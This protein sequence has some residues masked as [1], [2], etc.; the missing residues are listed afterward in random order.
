MNGYFDNASTSFPKPP[1]VGQWID[2]YLKGGGTYGRS[3]HRKSFEVARVVEDTRDRMAALL[4]ISNAENLVFCSSATEGA[5]TLL[6]G[7]TL[8]H[9]RVLVDAMSHNA[10]MRP[11]F[12]L[13]ESAGVEYST[14]PFHVDGTV[15]VEGLSKMM[16]S[17][18][19]LVIIN[20]ASNVNGIVQDIP[21]I[22]KVIGDV[23][24]LLDTSQSAGKVDICADNWGV[25]YLFFT[26][27]KG[28]LGPTGVGGFYASNPDLISPFKYGGTGSNS[29]SEQ[30]PS[31]N[32]DR[33]E[34]G[35]PNSLGIYGLY[36]ALNASIKAL[37]KPDDFV[38]FLS[39]VKALK[40]YEVYCAGCSAKQT[41][42]FS[43]VHRTKSNDELAFM[44]DQDFDIQVRSGLHCAPSAHKALGTF[45]QG[46]VRF[47]ASPFHSKDDFEYL[48]RTLE[49]IK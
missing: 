6:Q 11:L 14:I 12:H 20:H 24:L 7:I 43:L 9:K 18:I 37:H 16:N 42:L 46:T 26:G 32:P 13:R 5:N 36:G 21:S 17:S 3:G 15:D 40:Q 30:M 48:Y 25:S 29:E 10:V 4:G 31:Y 47:A 27:H 44:L 28:L 45:P 35:T 23:P 8:K 34:A 33:F 49:S 2:R 1:E 39:A 19:D 41:E 38:D 22:K